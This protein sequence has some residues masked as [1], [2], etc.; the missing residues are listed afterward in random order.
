MSML[1]MR[2]EFAK[3]AMQARLSDYESCISIMEYAEETKQTFAKVVAE[4]AYDM[5]DAMV[6][7]R[8]Q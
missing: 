3:A 2:D 7:A 4:Q 5:A 1:T 8:K 6:M